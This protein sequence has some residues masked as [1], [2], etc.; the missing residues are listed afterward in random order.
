MQKVVSR[1]QQSD[2]A[3]LTE[4]PRQGLQG[5]E[6][7][8]VVSPRDLAVDRHLNTVVLARKD[9]FHEPQRQDILDADG[10][11]NPRTVG[12]MLVTK[13]SSKEIH[14]I[15]AHLAGKGSDK[16]YIAGVLEPLLR[17][18][19]VLAG[20]FNV[21]LRVKP[22][23]PD[24]VSYPRLQQ[25]LHQ[26]EH[27]P[28]HL[29]TSNKQRSP[30]QAQVSKMFLQDFSMKDFVFLGENFK[31]TQLHGL[32]PRTRTLPDAGVPSDHAPL[33]FDLEFMT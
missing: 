13:A 28:R 5:L 23:L 33:S 2:I 12:C 17:P 6:D 30:F 1:I 8:W 16:K 11:I 24:M 32:V 25:F 20:D 9:L 10:R 18:E 15:G 31:S 21:D 4:V 14:I 3:V 27:L 26:A 19:T 7:F 22:L 29:G